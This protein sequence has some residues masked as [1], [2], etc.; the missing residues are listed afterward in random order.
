M[1]K[2]KEDLGD[3]F[4]EQTKEKSISG[5]VKRGKAR[6]L[7]QLAW[8]IG[9]FALVSAGITILGRGVTKVPATS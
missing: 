3:S 5:F 4:V 2:S 9:G 7:A 1:S 6:F 8:M